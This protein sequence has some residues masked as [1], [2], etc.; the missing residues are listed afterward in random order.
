MGKNVLFFLLA[1]VVM[2]ITGCSD[3]LSFRDAENET[4][5]AVE[6][7]QTTEQ[8]AGELQATENVE[9]FDEETNDSAT[10]S[11]Q[12]G[13]GKFLKRKNRKYKK[14]TKQT[15]IVWMDT[16]KVDQEKQEKLRQT[17][18]KMDGLAQAQEV[19]FWGNCTAKV[20]EKRLNPDYQK[21]LQ[22]HSPKLYEEMK[23]K[24]YFT[25]EFMMYT[26]PGC[27]Q[28]VLSQTSVAKNLSDGEYVG[29]SLTDYQ[30]GESLDVTVVWDTSPAQQT[31]EHTISLDNQTMDVDWFWDENMMKVMMS[32]PYDTYFEMLPDAT[33]G[34][35]NYYIVKSKKG[36]EE[37]LR[38]KITKLLGQNGGIY[39]SSYYE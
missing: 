22:E 37:T 23:E 6:E 7:L 28:T 38:Q 2:T 36:Q 34:I 35:P 10:E 27:N 21:F 29:D 16:K 31:A 19:Y 32:I 18:Q 3:T 25:M 20:S 12:Q 26:Y 13:N 5:Q 9:D 30:A 24:G 15:F 33:E 11:S 17:I 39:E 8:A 14:G 1:A 4:E